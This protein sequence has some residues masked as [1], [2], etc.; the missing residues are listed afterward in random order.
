MT[1]HRNHK[2]ES[3]RARRVIQVGAT[4]LAMSAAL[5]VAYHH[6]VAGADDAPTAR[7]HAPTSDAT[8]SHCDGLWD[9]VPVLS[10]P[11]AAWESAAEG[12]GLSAQG[13]WVSLDGLSWEHLDGTVI[14]VAT[15]RSPSPTSSRELVCPTDGAGRHEAA[16]ETGRSL[17]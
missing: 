14:V 12:L 17:S 8:D 5:G 3:S 11:R 15:P 16:D 10:L 2:P 6:Q 7:A 1:S 4:A 13:S 9:R